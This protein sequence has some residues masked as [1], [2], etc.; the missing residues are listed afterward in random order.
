MMTRLYPGSDHYIWTYDQARDSYESPK[1]YREKDLAIVGPQTDYVGLN[2][3]PFSY[4]YF[5]F[6]YFLSGG[7][8]NLAG[9]AGIILGLS[10]VIPLVVLTEK[11]F[12]DR[13]ITVLAGLLFAAS[14][15]FVEYSRWIINFST[16]IPFL[17]WSYLLLW[18]GAEHLSLPGAK[19]AKAS[20]QQKWYAIPAL[21]LS[22]ISLGFAVQGELFLLSLIPFWWLFLYWQ[23]AKVRELAAVLLGIF[24]GL[25]PFLIAEVKFS[26]LGTKTFVGEFLGGHGHT[27][28]T[29]IA[30]QNVLEY[31]SHLGM[32]FQ[33][34][35]GG[36]SNLMGFWLLV[37]TLIFGGVV[38]LRRLWPQA[39]R[40]TRRAVSAIFGLFA[41]HSVL[42]TFNY[43]DVIFVNVGLG[44]VMIVLVSFC[45][46]ALW[47]LKYRFLSGAL[48]IATFFFAGYQLYVNTA[49]QKPLEAYGFIQDGILYSQKMEMVE[50]MYE[51]A[52]DE[53]PF[54]MTVIGTP[55]GVRTVWASLFEQYVRR[56]QAVVPA[57][58]GYKANGYPGE[59][60]F[61]AQDHPEDVHFLIL[62]SNQS[63][64]SGPIRQAAL[65]DQNQSTYIVEEYELY[66]YRIQHRRPHTAVDN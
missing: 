36:L 44:M 30:A 27:V 57:W 49:D 66:G 29:E 65:D 61:P 52:G 12:G 10:T 16:S 37:V 24:I 6:F 18:M 9:I 42:F 34:T 39:P 4:Y 54:S 28:S 35:I 1:I 62:E 26:F 5:G 51:V 59:D 19:D 46:V 25:A 7:D 45:L 56:H 8:P 58:Y 50:L 14:Y 20:T 13:R 17:A 47:D 41:A 53:Q 38:G 63:L 64:L 40:D 33:H 15:E 22:G 23:R 31:L 60:L 2:H 32:T 43:P 55:Y 11:M 48:V 3:G 21:V